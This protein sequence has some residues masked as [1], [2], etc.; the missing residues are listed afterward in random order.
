MYLFGV[1][2]AQMVYNEAIFF[3]GKKFIISFSM[4][5]LVLK[6]DKDSFGNLETRKAFFYHHILNVVTL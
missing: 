6:S 2:L 4:C 1:S 3:C 5:L